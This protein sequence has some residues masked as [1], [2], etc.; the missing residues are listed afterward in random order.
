[1]IFQRKFVLALLT[2]VFVFSFSLALYAAGDGK[3][4]INTAG[5]EELAKLERI[6]EKYAQRI[7]EY[8][9][10]NGPFKKPEGIMNVKGIGSK[11]WESNKDR[12]VV[13]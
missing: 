11:T 8:R 1:M 9:E 6:G 13:E 2:A 7:I 10:L 3:I 4:N 12:I 5:V